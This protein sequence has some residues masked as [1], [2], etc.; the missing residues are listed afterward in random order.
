MATSSQKLPPRRQGI[1]LAILRALDI[2][3]AAGFS[4]VMIAYQAKL[5]YPATAAEQ[6]WT[7]MENLGNREP[8]RGKNGQD[9]FHQFPIDL[10]PFVPLFCVETCWEL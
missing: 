3:L 5:S 7:M 10:Y 1:V 6:R 9:H 2:P 4:A 8:G